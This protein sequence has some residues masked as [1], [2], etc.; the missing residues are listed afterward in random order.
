MRVSCLLTLATGAWSTSASQPPIL[1]DAQSVLNQQHA[2]VEKHISGGDR[3]QSGNSSAII[4]PSLFAELE[5]LARVVDITYCVGSIGAGIQDPFQCPSRCG[6]FP[7]FELVTV[8]TFA[9][10]TMLR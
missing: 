10:S 6:D 5:E 7:S 1:S 2:A 8:R 3:G 4:S 9:P